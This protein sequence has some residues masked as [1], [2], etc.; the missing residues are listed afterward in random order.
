M[1]LEEIMWNIA[2]VLIMPVAKLRR[3]VAFF[4]NNLNK[5]CEE[6]QSAEIN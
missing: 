3:Y 1:D 2:D 5:K 6:N 4:I